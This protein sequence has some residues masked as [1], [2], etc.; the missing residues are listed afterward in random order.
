MFKLR[1]PNNNLDKQR[2]CFVLEVSLTDTVPF[3]QG[4]DD[5]SRREEII[6]FLKSVADGVSEIVGENYGISNCKWS[7]KTKTTE[8]ITPTE[9]RYAGP[10]LYATNFWPKAVEKGG[11]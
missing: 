1:A 10:T 2:N 11:K 7:V 3:S 6:E 8:I 9:E 5:L 4:G